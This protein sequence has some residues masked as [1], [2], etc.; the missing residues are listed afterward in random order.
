MHQV[1]NTSYLAPN[2]FAVGAMI[3]VLHWRHV[4]GRCSKHFTQVLYGK[5]HCF[6]LETSVWTSVG[7][8]DGIRDCNPLC[9]TGTFPDEEPPKKGHGNT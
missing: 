9:A 1:S 5:N 4:T 7:V 6:W 2:I 3:Q 8:K